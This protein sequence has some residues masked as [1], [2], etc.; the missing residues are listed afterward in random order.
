MKHQQ[1]SI[2]LFSVLLLPLKVNA[3]VT[4]QPWVEVFGTTNGEQLGKYVT[5][6]TPSANLPYK[7]AVSKIGSTGIYRLNSP[8]DTSAQLRFLG[9]NLLTGDLNNDGLKDIVLTKTVSGYDTVFVY[10][11]TVTGIDTLNPL[12]IP[13]EGRFETFAARAIGD[14]NN[15]GF[16]DLILTAPGFPN[17]GGRGKVYFFFGPNFT[18][19]PSAVRLGDTTGS[20]IGYA[21]VGD[22]NNDGKNDFVTGGGATPPHGNYKYLRIYWGQPD[23]L[24]LNQNIELRTSSSAGVGLAVFDANGDDIVDLLWT[25]QDSQ[26]TRINVHFGRTNFDSIPDLQLQNPG[27]GTFGSVI[28][29]SGDM[30]GDGFND[31]VVGCPR[32]SITSGSVLV[33]GGGPNIDRFVD[34]TRSFGSESGFGTSVSGLG[35]I[36]NDGFADIIVGAPHD[37]FFNDRGYWGIFKGDS[38]IRVTSVRENDNLPAAF[39]LHQ[40]YPNPFNPVT[41]IGYGLRAAAFL[42][43]E[44]YDLLGKRVAVLVQEEKAPRN[45]TTQFDGSRHASGVYLYR[46]SARTKSG[47]VFTDTKRMLLIK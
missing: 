7:A 38:T 45:Y 19:I 22:L 21:A 12:K 47:K 34:A 31:V 11:G 40:A 1:I 16:V 32:S 29:N 4:L 35:D 2:I 18:S 6:I 33:Y 14:V 27:V 30:N 44:V 9:E 8:S 37:P 26:D 42:T 10:W 20:H 39:I 5:V 25:I 41:T 17:L 24:V 13:S 3:Q 28:M 15:D 43:I 36:N 46:M 23:T